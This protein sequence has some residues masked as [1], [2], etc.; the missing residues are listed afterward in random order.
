MI[1]CYLFSSVILLGSIICMEKGGSPDDSKGGPSGPQ[2]PNMDHRRPFYIIAHMVNS[3]EEVDEYLTKGANAIESNIEFDSNGTVLG[4]FHGAPCDCFRTCMKRE[5]IDDFLEFIRDVTSFP[6]S[7]HKGKVTLLFLDLRTA[8]LSNKAKVKAGINIARS[9][10]E[11]LWSD[12]TERNRINVLLS[13]PSVKERDVIRGA[14]AYIMQKASPKL[15]DNIGFDVGAN[16]PLDK[17]SQMYKRLKIR[18]HRWQGDGLSNC[19]RFIMP[20]ER[21]LRAI[22]L[23]NA[24]KGFIDKVYHW[25]IDF[26][27]YITRSI[28]HGVDGII[29]NRPDNVRMV[30][31]SPEFRN[32][33]KVADITDNP[34][35]NFNRGLEDVEVHRDTTPELL[36]GE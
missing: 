1:L 8:K 24:G 9:L 29:S 33:L 19:V 13:I 36:G 25:T 16:E 6:D 32:I 3:L 26:P 27:F 11:Y 34:W 10:V 17:I 20:V 4:T 28:R 23:R 15:L 21:L 22:R 5:K 30:V 2:H 31:E 18:Q 14:I 35:Q 7:E 12:V